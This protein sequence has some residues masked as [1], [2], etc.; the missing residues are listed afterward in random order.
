MGSPNEG[1]SVDGNGKS[2]TNKNDT[3]DALPGGMTYVFCFLLLL[4]IIIIAFHFHPKEHS[5]TI[6]PFLYCLFYVLCFFFF[7]FILE[8]QFTK[9][10][11]DLFEMDLSFILCWCQIVMLL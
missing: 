9:I 8:M 6:F 3:T 5:F 11:Y 7:I 1:T 4:F 10:F 2:D